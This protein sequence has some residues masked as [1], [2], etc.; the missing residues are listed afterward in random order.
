MTN[1]KIKEILDR[2][3]GRFGWV[4]ININTADNY[5][6]MPLTELVEIL[7]KQIPKKPEQMRERNEEMID[8]RELIK[9]LLQWKENSNKFAGLKEDALIDKVIA[10]ITNMSIRTRIT[11]T[12]L[13]DEAKAEMCQQC[14]KNEECEAKGIEVYCPLDRI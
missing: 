9:T 1:E 3:N 11:V 8:E 14:T 5:L 12:D 2:C 7:E 10:E 6:L 4:Q 13:L